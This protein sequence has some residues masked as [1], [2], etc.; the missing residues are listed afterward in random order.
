MRWL[1]ALLLLA[2]AHRAAGDGGLVRTSQA[3]GPYSI[4]VFSA[5]TP[6]RAGP[7]D[8]SVLVQRDGTPVLDLPVSIVL[9]QGDTRLEIAATHAAATN[10]LL[11]AAP[12]VLPAPGRW[13]VNVTAGVETVGFA[14]DAAPAASGAWTF[15]PYLVLPFVLIVVFA[16]HQWLLHHNDTTAQRRPS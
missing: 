8:L 2:C 1:A 14:L 13:V 4:T 11:Y 10:K 9:R 5:P 6:L 15:W 16:L 12:F 3:A 7:I